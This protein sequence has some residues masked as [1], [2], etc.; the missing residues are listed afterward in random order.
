MGALPEKI[1]CKLVVGALVIAH[2][3]CSEADL[4]AVIDAS[5]DAG[6]LPNLA[7]LRARF[8]PDPEALPKVTVTLTPLSAYDVLTGAPAVGAPA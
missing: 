3:R 7:D 1:T 6:D 8:A 2:E 4:A 5:L